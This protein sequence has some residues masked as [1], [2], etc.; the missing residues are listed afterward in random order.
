MPRA[1]KRCSL[2]CPNPVTTN[3]KCVEH[4]PPRE[5]WKDKRERVFLKSAE[6]A[7]QRRRVLYRDNTYFGG[8]RLGFDGCTSVATQVDH[9]IPTWYTQVE[10]VTDEEL[11]GVCKSC[12]DNKSS[13][14]GVQA[15]R[16]KRMRENGIL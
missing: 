7:R 10:E 8:C 12:H 6:W 4:Q 11:Q 3:G 5:A 1:P 16:I 9:I 13:F 2:S 14:E 15:R